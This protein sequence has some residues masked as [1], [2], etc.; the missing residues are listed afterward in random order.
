M[1]ELTRKERLL[2]TLAGEPVDRP[3][4]ICPGGMMNMAV[5]EA[6]D[7]CGHAWPSVH[8]DAAGMAALTR[9]V[10]GSGGLENLGAPFCM[11]LE[12]EAMGAAVSMGSRDTEPRVTTYVM[13]D[14]GD[15][16]ALTALDPHAGRAA[17]VADA[18]RLM[19]ASSPDVPVIA[20]LSGPVSLATSLADPL[21][22]YKALRRD[23]ERARALLEVCTQAAITFGDALVDAGADVV[24][25][26]DPSA[27]GE[28]LGGRAFEQFALPY[29]N[30]IVRHF[31]ARGVP[32]IVHI[33]GDVRALGPVLR[34]VAAP[35]ISVDSI[36]RI[37]VLRQL[38]PEHLT[39]GNISTYLLEYGKPRTLSMVA[40]NLL[41][42]GVDIMAPACGIGARTPLAN[43]RAVA[44]VLAARNGRPAEAMRAAG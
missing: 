38:A 31:A 10:C 22:F 26:A 4:F 19:A 8:E 14:L 42:Q 35:V 24:C 27:T 30:D 3:A 18:V 43:L 9:A 20:D 13:E 1:N 23:P 16:D 6:M 41:R 15:L 17:I 5:T 21:P 34:G 37:D 25:V 44:D 29:I 12:A 32:S 2:L 28:L 7:E 36:V 40:E 11:T 39:M 33:C